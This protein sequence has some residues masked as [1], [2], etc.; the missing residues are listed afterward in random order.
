M[1]IELLDQLANE[2]EAHEKLKEIASELIR[3]NDQLRQAVVDAALVQSK[4]LGTIRSTGEQKDQAR[5]QRDKLL[6][7][8]KELGLEKDSLAKQLKEKNETVTW[9]ADEVNRLLGEVES[10]RQEIAANN[11]M[12]KQAIKLKDMLYAELVSLCYNSLNSLVVSGGIPGSN[13][14]EKLERMSIMWNRRSEMIQAQTE[15]IQKLS[16]SKQQAEEKISLLE[17]QYEEM[18]S[19]FWEETTRPEVEER[20]IMLPALVCWVRTGSVTCRAVVEIWLMRQGLI[21]EFCYNQEGESH[22]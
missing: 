6:Q 1:S 8:T 16:L 15:H 7:T 19:L 18:K 3:E 13:L 10:L 12:F 20:E 11:E 21:E 14:Q 4:L 17:R 2:I 5:I 9:A 22:V